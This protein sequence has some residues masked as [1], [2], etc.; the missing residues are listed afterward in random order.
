[1]LKEYIIKLLSDDILE[2]DSYKDSQGRGFV[3][4]FVE[5]FGE[6]LDEVVIK[7]IEEY[8]VYTIDINNADSKFIEYY[9]DLQGDVK[10]FGVTESLRRNIVKYIIAIYQIKGTKKSIHQILAIRG[11]KVLSITEHPPLEYLY[12][13]PGVNYDDPVVMYDKSCDTCSEITI[14]MER[15]TPDPLSL[16][17]IEIIYQL[18]DLVIP[19]NTNIRDV[20]VNGSSVINLITAIYLDTE[21]GSGVVTPQGDMFY[22]EDDPLGEVELSINDVGDLVVSGTKTAGYSLNNEGDLIYSF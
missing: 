1:M 22:S 17:E 7:S 8:D 3:Q 6:D 21:P 11:F 4:R 5:I 20:Q 12:D 2:R 14:D 19:I 13:E 16:E 10:N 18:I 9:E 15:N